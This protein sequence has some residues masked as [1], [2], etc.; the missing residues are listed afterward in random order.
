VSEERFGFGENWRH[1]LDVLDDERIAEAER[2]LVTWLGQD[3]IRGR[4][5]LDAGCGSGL[6]SLAALRLGAARIHSFDYDP[7]S[8]GCAME[9]RRRYGRDEVEWTVERG[10]VLDA[11]YVDG[12]GRFDVVY[13]WG[14][15]HH[16]GD[17]WRALR[18]VE[19]AVAPDGRLFIAIY[20][21]QRMVS[22]WWRLVKRT[23]NRLPEGLRVPFAVA[24]MAPRELASFGVQTL[25][26]R[27]QDYVH[28]WTRYK[29]TRGMSR[30]HDLLDWVGGYPFEVAKPEEI[31]AL[32]HERGY[33]LERLRTC[34]GGLGC[35]EFVLR[36]RGPDSREATGALGA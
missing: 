35:N 3:R 9:L 33:E 21:D 22:R 25:R 34:G 8:V 17:M 10:D 14:V 20:N 4:T 32:Y 15:L 7:D 19:H 1:F 29:A 5:F 27:P 13:S 18:T 23:Y 36:R 28:S 31:F 2:S 26:G 6:F 16:T 11:A 12:L 24:V 30:W